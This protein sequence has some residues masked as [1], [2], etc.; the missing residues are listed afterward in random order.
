M[1]SS[2]SV[3]VGLATAALVVLQGL[4]AWYGYDRYVA[5]SHVV[6]AHTWP[7]W[8]W[9]TTALFA[10][11]WFGFAAR[12]VYFLHLKCRKRPITPRAMRWAQVTAAFSLAASVVFLLQL[13]GEGMSS[14]LDAY[15]P[16]KILT[17]LGLHA[18]ALCIHVGLYVHLLT[19]PLLAA[20]HSD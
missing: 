5:P 13:V 6:D 10:M 15:A 20:Y 11:S 19:D 4:L 12:S 16:E 2:V 1:V 18:C 9:G 3:A 14:H 17:I 8:Y 7:G